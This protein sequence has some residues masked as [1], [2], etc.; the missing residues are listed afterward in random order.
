DYYGYY[1]YVSSHFVMVRYDSHGMVDS[2]FGKN[3][4]V[5]DA[6]ELQRT[7]AISLQIDG[8]ILVTGYGSH[9]FQIER[10]N[11]DGNPDTSFGIHG[12]QFNNFNF[13]SWANSI[14]ALPDGK[15]SIAGAANYD[16]LI[17]RLNK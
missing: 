7:T 9:P 5:A 1:Y 3:G 13:N 12:K 4:I 14:L 8:K 17:T 2:S 16:F 10:Y 15:I 6:S 11:N